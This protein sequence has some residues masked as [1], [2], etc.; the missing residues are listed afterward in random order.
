MWV[1]S[2]GSKVQ[3]D[4]AL[5]GFQELMQSSQRLVAGQLLLRRRQS[6]M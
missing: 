3:R 1:G 5:E 6:R 4:C 2:A